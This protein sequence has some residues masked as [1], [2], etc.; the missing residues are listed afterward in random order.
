MAKVLKLQEQTPVGPEIATAPGPDIFRGFF[1]D[2][3]I[4]PDEIL[5]RESGGKGIDLYDEMER[6]DPHLYAVLRTR[7]VFVLSKP[8]QILPAADDERS[9]EIADFVR[10]MI[11]R[12]PRWEEQLDYLLDAIGKGFAVAEIIWGRRNG[13]IVVEAIKSKPQRWFVFDSQN[14]LRLLTSRSPFSGVELPE[15]KFI[16]LTY[17]GRHD[18]PY[19]EGEIGRVYWY[20]W[21]KKHGLKFWVIFTEKFGQPIAIGKYPSGATAEQRDALFAAIEALQTDLGVTIPETMTVELLEAQRQSSINSYKDLVVFLDRGITKGILGQTLTTEESERGTQ[22]L[23]TVHE[24]V[25]QDIGE[26]DARLLECA[27]NDQLIR[28]AVDF[29]FP[30][31]TEYPRWKILTEP[32]ED[33]AE[34]ADRDKKLFVDMRVPIGV[35]YFYDRYKLPRPEAGQVLLEPAQFAEE[36]TEEEVLDLVGRSIDEAKKLYGELITK[37]LRQAIEA[38]ED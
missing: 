21:F 32:E 28:W 16:V 37:A 36:E 15:R 11:G 7:R 13:R 31:V 4:N 17:R 35:D 6:K 33:L 19:G 3:K 10:G 22:A 12:I 2:I 30:G 1:G 24:E 8:T 26:A 25:R 29:N 14:R 34:L 38:I 18:N 27:I 20:W 5:R 23:G 9:K